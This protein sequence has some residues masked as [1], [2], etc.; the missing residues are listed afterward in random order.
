MMPSSISFSPNCDLSFGVSIL[1]LGLASQAG[2]FLARFLC[3]R[4][5][6]LA[7]SFIRLA[8]GTVRTVRNARSSRDHGVSSGSW[9]ACFFALIPARGFR[10]GICAS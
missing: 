6:S 4:R 2:L 9:S 7:S 1:E 3:R 10:L 5:F 8:F